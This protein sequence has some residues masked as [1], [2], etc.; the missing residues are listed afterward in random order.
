MSEINK[1]NE[2][3]LPDWIR[4]PALF[5][6]EIWLE[7]ELKTVT[8]TV[9]DT[10]NGLHG[11]IA[12]KS[13]WSKTYKKGTPIDEVK[14]DLLLEAITRLKADASIALYVKQ[15]AGEIIEDTFECAGAFD[16]ESQQPFVQFSCG[17]GFEKHLSPEDARLIAGN[18]LQ[19]AEAAESDA[20]F[21]KWI[22]TL[23]IKEDYKIAQML[24][25]LREIR[26]SLRKERAGE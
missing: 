2:R 18:L 8:L 4:K 23:G 5:S 25:T 26:D 13:S 12:G 20:M 21:I 14:A 1:P 3:K 16:R 10:R 6:D 24:M 19:A 15:G 7:L 22:R 9:A 11:T 17:I